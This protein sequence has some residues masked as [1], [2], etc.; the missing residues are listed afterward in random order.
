M[1][2]Y[3]ASCAVLRFLLHY[4]D[5][6]RMKKKPKQQN[7]T[8][9]YLRSHRL[10]AYFSLPVY[11]CISWSLENLHC[12]E[13]K[14]ITIGF[15]IKCVHMWT[16]AFMTFQNL[17]CCHKPKSPGSPKSDVPCP[18]TQTNKKKGTVSERRP[19]AVC[20]WWLLKQHWTEQWQHAV[21]K[22]EQ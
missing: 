8:R 10:Y 12:G 21:E 22:T 1:F 7:V 3:I 6:V 18:A 2:V 5:C 4:R 20:V 14:L 13:N 15:E 16:V 17:Y 9:G 11:P 19:A